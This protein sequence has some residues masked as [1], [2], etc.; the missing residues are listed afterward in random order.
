MA[1]PRLTVLE[2][3]EI[4]A[5]HRTALRVLANVGMLVPDAEARAILDKGGARVDD[6][7]CQTKRYPFDN[8]KEPHL[9]SLACT[10]TIE[11]VPI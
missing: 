1:L 11:N 3:A 7:F 5:I 9:G 6:C 2:D 10:L 4:E 8:R